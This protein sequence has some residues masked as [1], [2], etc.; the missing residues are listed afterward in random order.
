MRIRTAK[1]LLVVVDV[2]LVA[3]W[4]AVIADLLPEAQRFRDYS[5]PVVQAWNWSFLPLDL[6]AV[7]CGLAGVRMATTGSRVGRSVLTVGLTLTFCAGFMAVSFW[8]F[9][10]DFDAAW[11]A[12][13]IALMVVPLLVHLAMLAED[14]TEDRTQDRVTDRVRRATS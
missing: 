4:V 5:N 14:R 12:P 9:Y 13:N 1:T 6:L 2:A 3:Y 11:W 10:G 7:A 8:A